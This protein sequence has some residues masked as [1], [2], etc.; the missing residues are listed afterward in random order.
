VSRPASGPARVPLPWAWTARSTRAWARLWFTYGAN[1]EFSRQ[2]GSWLSTE[3]VTGDVLVDSLIFLAIAMLLT[4]TASLIVRSRML[5]GRLPAEQ[6][7][8]S[9]ASF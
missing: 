5:R 1:H 3:R 4:R 7:V 6:P 2:L 9:G 8:R